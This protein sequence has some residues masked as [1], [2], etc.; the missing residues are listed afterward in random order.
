M[1][2][3]KRALLKQWLESGKAQLQPLTFPQRE[4][5]ENSPVPL[6]D[7]ANHICCL[8]NVR[9]AITPQEVERAIQRVVERQEALRISFLPGKDRPVQMVRE[10]GETNFRFRQVPPAK[11]SEHIE[12]LAR[13]V[14]RE[15]FELV[16]GPLYRV[17]LLSRGSDDHVLVFAIHHAIAD[18]WTLGV[19]IQDL[20]VAYMQ[21]LRGMCD[22]LPPVPQ[23]YTAWGATE[24]AFWQPPEIEQRARFWRSRLQGSPRLWTRMEGPATASGALRRLVSH[25]PPDLA[26]AA[27]ELARSSG[28]TLFSTLL[29]AFQITI[30]RWTNTQDIIVGSPV[31]NRTKPTVR[32]TMGYCSGVIPLRG[33]VEAERTFSAAL[34]SVHQE[35]V[36]CFA[37]AMPFAEI[38]QAVGETTKPGHPPIF[39][40][41]FALQNHPIPDVAL[42]GLSAKLT[43]RSTG[44]AR[45]HL[46][47]EITEEGEQLEVVWLFRP[48]LFPQDEI[49]DLGRMYQS[50][51]A[52]VCRKPDCRIDAITI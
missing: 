15:P 25:F 35:T 23:S 33:P 40:I 48:E 10:N 26:A 2:G 47:C 6:A 8:I 32:E 46:A 7:M 42:P 1:S 3:D 19:F 50:V 51:L 29:S 20:C 28:A 14:F 36:E 38:A 41:R 17:E 5:W 34:K 13:E 27:R 30:S 4:L 21:G 22:P 45:F 16:Q 24:R 49:E 12:E 43:M 37:N 44:T 39:E 31:A 18:G 11:D 9:G 52:W